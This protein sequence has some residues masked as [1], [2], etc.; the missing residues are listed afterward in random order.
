M[1]R[2]NFSYHVPVQNLSAVELGEGVHPFLHSELLPFLL[3][4]ARW[5]LRP[6]QWMPFYFGD[7]CCLQRFQVCTM[8][9]VRFR[10]R[11]L[12]ALRLCL[13]FFHRA[14]SLVASNTGTTRAQER[15]RALVWPLRARCSHPRT[16][17]TGMTSLTLFDSHDFDFARSADG[18]RTSTSKFIVRERFVRG[19]VRITRR[20]MTAV[21]YP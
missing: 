18:A 20:F 9:T 1:G 5:N 16:A 4:L 17:I 2:T 11:M 14:S 10:C 12:Y 13:F 19:M 6:K 21:E 15:Q 8:L 7:C 3:H